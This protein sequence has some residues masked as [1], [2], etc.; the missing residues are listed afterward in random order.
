MLADTIALDDLKH[1]VAH[2]SNQGVVEMGDELQEFCFSAALLDFG[3]RA[4]GSKWQ[5]AL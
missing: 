4:D 5:P 3:S 2:S 1:S